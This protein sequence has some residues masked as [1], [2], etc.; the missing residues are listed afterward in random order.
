MAR[1]TREAPQ[2]VARRL[3][4][5]YPRLS[6]LLREG[7]SSLW[8]DDQCEAWA[9]KAKPADVLAQ[10][11]AWLGVLDAALAKRGADLPCTPQ[12]LAWLAHLAVE[13]EDALAG[14]PKAEALAAKQAREAALAEAR[15]V[16]AR[17][18]SRMLLLVGGDEQR[19]AALAIAARDPKSLSALHTL[20]SQWRRE[21]RLRVLADELGLDEPLLLAAEQSARVL[22][23]AEALASAYA[24]PTRALEGRL[25][26]ELQALFG[27][28]QAAREEGLDVPA[29][30]PLKALALDAAA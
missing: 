18:H 24:R 5:K 21:A 14:K 19:G 27:A 1:R 13:L 3:V 9:K 26:R 8:T 10:A 16:R 2:S 23:D 4:K 15:R 29:L 30:K 11:N 28:M 17:L 12:R 7:F 6:P 20:L 25:L 22:H